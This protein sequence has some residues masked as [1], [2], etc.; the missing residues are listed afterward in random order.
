MI[1]TGTASSPETATVDREV[2]VGEI[3]DDVPGCEEGL[4]IEVGSPHTPADA[5]EP[6]SNA[7]DCRL[8]P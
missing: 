1:Y 5:S 2:A 4:R 3:L 6:E 7:F 8:L